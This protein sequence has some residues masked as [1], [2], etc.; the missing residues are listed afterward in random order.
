MDVEVIRIGGEFELYPPH[1]NQAKSTKSSSELST[2]YSFLATLL[3][4]GRRYL[5]NLNFYGAF[6][7]FSVYQRPENQCSPQRLGKGGWIAVAK[8]KGVLGL[9]LYVRL[10]YLQTV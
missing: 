10:F 8:K 3:S 9:G 6:K 2:S 7:L 4:T 1:S 5:A